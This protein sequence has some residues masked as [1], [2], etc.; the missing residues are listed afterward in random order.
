M[1]VYGAPGRRHWPLTRYEKLW[2]A[3]APG[4]PGTF[5]PH[6]RLQRKPL[7]SD[8][9]MH[10]GTCAT[11]VPWCIPGLLTRGGGEKVPGIPGAWATRNFV[12]MVRGPLACLGRSMDSRVWNVS[13]NSETNFNIWKPNRW[14][15]YWPFGINLFFHDNIV[16]NWI[17]FQ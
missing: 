7:V 11:H 8:P 14:C 9:G 6:H 13:K 17:L 3:H 5:F 15:R 10:H 1:L 12:Y 4:M 2:V 16:F